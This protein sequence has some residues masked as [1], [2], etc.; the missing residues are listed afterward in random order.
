VA[1]TSTTKSDLNYT[2]YRL[3][4]V[5]LLYAEASN[6]A[7]SGPNPDAISYVNQIR[8][9]ANLAPIG[10]LSQ[11]DFEHEVWLERYFELCFENKMWFDMLRTLKV[12]NDVTGNWD[13][14]VGHKTVWGATFTNSQL[15]FPLPKQ[16]TDV[17][18]NLLPNNPGF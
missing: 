2:V 8:A 18:P 5:Y 16:E 9:R 1:V 11:D 3:A 12:H 10:A 17:N 4:D 14:F 6:R 7:E 13:D 15:L